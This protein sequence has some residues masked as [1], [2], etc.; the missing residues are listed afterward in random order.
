MGEP[1]EARSLTSV[2]GGPNLTDK[3][4]CNRQVEPAEYDA[5]LVR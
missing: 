2:A 3:A 1:A 4:R 5:H